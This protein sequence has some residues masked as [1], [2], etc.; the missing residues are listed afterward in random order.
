MANLALHK[1]INTNSLDFLQPTERN[2]VQMLVNDLTEA[3]KVIKELQ[4]E[5]FSLKEKSRAKIETLAHEMVC[6]R[7]KFNVV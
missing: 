3:Q 5:N 2:H 1:E 7:C 4:A 6:L